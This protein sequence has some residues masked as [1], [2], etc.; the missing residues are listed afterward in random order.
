MT[1]WSW[2]TGEKNIF[3][4]L[5]ILIFCLYLTK[6]IVRAISSI[7]CV[8][9]HGVRDF[10][11]SMFFFLGDHHIYSIMLPLVYKT[12]PIWEDLKIWILQWQVC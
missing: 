1:L 11:F 2:T 8:E 9:I 5:K 3:V 12:V 4:T 6:A 7:L 10:A